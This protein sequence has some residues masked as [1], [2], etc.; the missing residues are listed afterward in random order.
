[1]EAAK[2]KMSA[3]RPA[4]IQSTT[5]S[6]EKHKRRLKG[7]GSAAGLPCLHQPAVAATLQGHHLVLEAHIHAP[8]QRSREGAEIHIGAAGHTGGRQGLI[9]WAALH[10]QRHPLAQ[11]GAIAAPLHP[12]EL[13]RGV[14]R[15]PAPAQEAHI[16]LAPHKTEMWHSPDKG[17]WILQFTALQQGS[18]ELQAQL[19]GSVDRQRLGD[20]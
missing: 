14:Q 9:E 6:T 12:F 1:M 17:G 10:H 19:K 15:L 4:V 18:P 5:T 2:Y 7:S 20:R 11:L 13:G 8:E 3:V 16:R